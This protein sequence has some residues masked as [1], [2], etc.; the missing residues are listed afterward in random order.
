MINA[1]TVFRAYILSQLTECE[2][3]PFN[4]SKNPGNE[5]S[6][7]PASSICRPPLVDKPAIA[8]DM[9]TL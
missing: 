5:V 3:I 8:K 1:L 6:T 2:H 7:Q 9:A 4:S